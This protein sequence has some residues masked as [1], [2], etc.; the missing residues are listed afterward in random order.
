MTYAGF[1]AYSALLSIFPFLIFLVALAGFAGG[2]ALANTLVEKGF[3]LLPPQVMQTLAPLVRETL[4]ARHEGLLTLSAAG[5]LWVASSGI[6]SLRTG[7]NVAHHL[8]ETRP[9]WWRRLQ[10][11]GLV[12]AGAATALLA[13]GLVI[14]V[15]V[16]L[17]AL[18]GLLPLDAAER[19]LLAVVRYGLAFGLLSGF[20]L[21]LYRWLPNTQYHMREL[22]PGACVA[23]LLWLGLASLFTL[24]LTHFGRYDRTY[25]SLGGIIATLVFFHFSIA[26]VLI[27]AEVNAA[28]HARGVRPTAATRSVAPHDRRKIAGAPAHA[29]R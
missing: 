20:I 29:A 21:M 7:L 4:D 15:P 18:A 6:E 24:Y 16:A 19:A 27:G 9:L 14:V 12:V 3:A 2:E 8:R 22:W 1:A 28:R 23:A 25:G 10:G 26:V 13:A 11:L 17:Q 5:A